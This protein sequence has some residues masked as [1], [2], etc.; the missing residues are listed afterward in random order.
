MKRKST[1]FLIAALVLAVSI[2]LFALAE[3]TVG[4]QPLDG[5]G[6]MNGRGGY[7]PLAQDVYDANGNAYSMANGYSVDADGYCYFLDEGGVAQR[8]FTRAADGQQTALQIGN[9]ALCWALDG[10]EATTAPVPAA[11]MNR[12]FSNDDSNAFYGRGCGRWN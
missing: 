11:M 6:F 7:A 5:T 12:R 9:G 2:P 4:T 3:T 10:D 8:L 1:L